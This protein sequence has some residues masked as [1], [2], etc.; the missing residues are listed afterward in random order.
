MGCRVCCANTAEVSHG[1]FPAPRNG[2]QFHVTRWICGTPNVA[3]SVFEWLLFRGTSLSQYGRAGPD[4]GNRTAWKG[5]VAVEEP[6]I[7]TRSISELNLGRFG[8]REPIPR[9]VLPPPITRVRIGPL[10]MLLLSDNRLC[11]IVYD[12][13]VESCGE[14]GDQACFP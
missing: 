3:Q 6:G 9:D 4:G 1:P 7:T 14:K 5:C 10:L 13:S 11:R 2:S 12:S 8:S